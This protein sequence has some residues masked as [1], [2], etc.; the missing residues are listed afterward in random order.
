[1]YKKQTPPFNKSL[2]VFIL[3]PC[4]IIIV[5][6]LIHYQSVA[7]ENAKVTEG[8]Q[9][10]TTLETRDL[11]TMEEKIDYM[12]RKAI[13]SGDYS[14]LFGNAVV[15]GDSIAEGL[16]LYGFLSPTSLV[17]VMGKSTEN[18]LEDVPSL[19]NLAP[20]NVF[21]ELGLNDISHPDS[22]LDSYLS[23]YEK[24]I[25]AVRLQLPNT[26]I[27]LCSIF[28]VTDEALKEKPEFSQIE[29][30]NTALAEMAKRK[31]IHYIDTYTFL[32]NNPQYHEQDGIH[33]I[34]EFY[35]IW[36]DTLVNNSDLKNLL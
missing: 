26:Q 33:V 14:A 27:Y 9:A 29:T 21:F 34:R 35:P 12:K 20:R 28:P 16:G 25:D 11:Y 1:M 18:S 36:M 17:A 30:Y 6:L 10:L 31:N 23:H 4:I 24:I 22:T 7:R 32:K 3:I 2:V 5:V 13:D 8:I 15:F 19:V